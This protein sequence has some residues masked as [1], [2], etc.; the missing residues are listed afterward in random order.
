MATKKVSQRLQDML[1]VCNA[2][3]SHIECEVIGKNIKKAETSEMMKI[4]SGLNDVCCE[5]KKQ[6]LSK[7]TVNM[8]KAKTSLLAGAKAIREGK[9]FVRKI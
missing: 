1:K 6:M 2:M 9:A 7:T 3:K 4:Q 5:L 8:E